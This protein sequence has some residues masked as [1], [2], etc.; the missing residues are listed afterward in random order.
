M[1]T[2]N[3]AAACNLLEYKG[4][5][6]EQSEG[7]GRRLMAMIPSKWQM[8]CAAEDPADHAEGSSGCFDCVRACP[9]PVPELSQV[10]HS[11]AAHPLCVRLSERDIEMEEVHL[12]LTACCPLTCHL[13]GKL[14]TK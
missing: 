3:V 4:F 7:A 11:H 9:L 2:T 12:R 13:A 5:E 10:A 1:G 14:A 6:D 8:G